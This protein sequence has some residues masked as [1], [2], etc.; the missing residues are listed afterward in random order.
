MLG[1]RGCQYRIIKASPLPHRVVVV[2]SALVCHYRRKS[3]LDV[4]RGRVAAESRRGRGPEAVKR[5]QASEEEK[6]V[7][8]P[9]TLRLQRKEATRRLSPFT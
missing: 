9:I 6:V 8:L 3:E 7:V 2:L 1:L 5:G 4:D